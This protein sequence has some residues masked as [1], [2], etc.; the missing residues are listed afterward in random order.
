MNQILCFVLFLATVVVA[1]Q[2][3]QRKY[4]PLSDY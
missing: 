1:Q 4:S 3:E 2:K